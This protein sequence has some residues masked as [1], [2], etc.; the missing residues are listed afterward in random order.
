M[1]NITNR[2]LILK[3]M[4]KK[5]IVANYTFVTVI[6]SRSINYF[7]YICSIVYKSHL[8]KSKKTNL[9][10]SQRDCHQDNLSFDWLQ[11]YKHNFLNILTSNICCHKQKM[12]Q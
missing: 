8:S 3:P 1:M 10:L 9:Y 5:S 11:I 4:I 6:T 2:V 7:A 12:N